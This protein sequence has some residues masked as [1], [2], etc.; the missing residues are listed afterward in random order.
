MN[1]TLVVY[2]ELISK[3]HYLTSLNV[4]TG[5]VILA[6]L[7]RSTKGDV[8]LLATKLYEI[9][10]AHYERRERSELVIRSEGYVPALGQAEESGCVPIWFHTHP[11][12]SSPSPSKYDKHVDKQISDLFRLRSNNKFYGSLIVSNSN[13]QLK[14]T[15]H[16]EESHQSYPID[17]LLTVGSRFS[18]YTNN[19]TASYSLPDIFDR[20]IR[21]F[22]GDIQ[23]ILNNLRIT[24]VGCGGTGSAVAEQLVR[25]GV[26][27]FL[28]LDPDTLSTSNTTRV[29]GSYA[30]D[31]GHLKVDVLADHLRQI[32]PEAHIETTPKAITIEDVARQI[33]GT[34]IVFGCTD[35]NAGRLILSR[36]TTYFLLPVIDCG[37]ILTNNPNGRLDGIYGRVTVI[38]PGSA[39]L[40][41]RNRIDLS[42]ANSEMLPSQERIKRVGEGYAPSLAGI[43]PAV[44]TFT[45]MVAAAAV[46]ELLE[47]FAKYGADPIPSE[48]LLR[49]HDREVSTNSYAPNIG[50]YCDPATN[51]LGTGETIPFLEQT[52]QS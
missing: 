5:G 7:V 15:G 45:T 48:I 14:Y 30:K 12:K 38:H 32:A 8:R 23:S 40:V 29:Y 4:E 6:K 41:C 13:G 37:V 42:R 34:D 35:D 22:G 43:E 47:R 16:I 31:V 25:L 49:I 51:K 50:H 39:C 46:N 26:R 24:I 27:H 44:V 3:I 28:L 21:A 19:D 52:W 36:L 2:E 1:V 17:R 18:L 9:P 20:N 33:I 11:K 10:D